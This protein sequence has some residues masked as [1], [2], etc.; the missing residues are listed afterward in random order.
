VF[1]IGLD[2]MWMSGR[3]IYAKNEGQSMARNCEETRTKN[4]KKQEQKLREKIE[5]KQGQKL[6][7]TLRESKDKE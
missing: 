3:G 5:R 6:R 4:D 2:E 7:E 1:G